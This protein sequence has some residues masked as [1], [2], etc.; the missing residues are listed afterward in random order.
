M[1]GSEICYDNISSC[2]LVHCNIPTL[3]WASSNKSSAMFL[4]L[5]FCNVLFTVSLSSFILDEA[6]KYEFSNA[7]MYWY[8]MMQYCKFL[9]NCKELITAYNCK[10][11][12]LRILKSYF[13]FSDN[14]KLYEML[15]TVWRSLSDTK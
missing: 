12:F 15:T 3:D 9:I 10:K 6:C 11:H 4:F 8:K 14:C 7:L 1:G 13:N 2:L 5:I